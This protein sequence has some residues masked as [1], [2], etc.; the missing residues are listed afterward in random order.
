MLKTLASQASSRFRVAAAGCEADDGEWLYDMI[1]YE[2]EEREG[3]RLFTRLPMVMECENTMGPIAESADVKDDFQKLVQ[4][5]ADVRVWI[6][7]A[8]SPEIASEHIKNCKRQIRAFS[9]TAPGDQYVIAVLI[10]SDYSYEIKRFPDG[11]ATN[12]G[13]RTGAPPGLIGETAEFGQVSSRSTN[14]AEGLDT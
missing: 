4:A 6:H 13:H 8:P 10:Y 14:S 3:K 9:E 11:N 2:E 12:S 7:L 1:W 5:R